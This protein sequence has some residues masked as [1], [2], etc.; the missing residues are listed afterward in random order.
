MTTHTLTLTGSTAALAAAMQAFDTASAGNPLPFGT[1]ANEAST[2]TGAGTPVAPVSI[3]SA[4]S[5]DATIPTAPPPPMPQTATIS[6]DDDEGDDVDDGTGDASGVDADGLPWDERI[7]SSNKKKS[8]NGRWMSRRGGP[9]D[10]ERAAIEAELRGATALA[11][12]A[13]LPP[14][15]PMPTATAEDAAPM[16]PAAVAPQPPAAPVPVPPPLPTAPTLPQAAPMPAADL[17]A[18]PATPVAAAP[19][20][21]DPT[22]FAGLMQVIGPKLGEA[23]GQIDATYLSVACQQCGINTLTDLALKPELIPNV[24]AQFRADGRW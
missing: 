3:P 5:G 6:Q 14:V 11:P 18:T 8:A 19:A 15:P 10:E 13:P 21:A 24:I 9:K 16:P 4:P 22:D 1:T 2:S 23:P 17:S 7:H 12:P 20:S